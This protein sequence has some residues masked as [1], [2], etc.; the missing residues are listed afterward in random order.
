MACTVIVGGFFGDEG[1]GKIASYLAISDELAAMVRAG[2]GTNAGHTVVYKGKKFKLRQ[3]PCGFVNEK[4]K[5]Y[6]SAGMLVDPEVILKEI[7]ET[8]TKERL[9]IDFQTGIIEPIHRERDKGTIISKKIG[10]TGSGS[11]PC[12][13]DR[14]S[15]VGKIAQ[16][17][18][19]LKEY[20]CDVALEVNEFIDAQENV[21]LEGTQGTF[22]S[23]YHGTYP[24]V[25][26]KDVCASAICSDVGI[27]PT[28]IDDVLVIFK[29]YVTRVGE[30]PLEGELSEEE[31]IR[32]GWQEKGT[33]TGRTRRASPFNYKLAKRTVFLNGATQCA[34]T[35]LD[36]VFPNVRGI[37]TF[38]ELPKE[39]I[40]FTHKI[41]AQL[42]I[43]VTLIGTGPGVEEIIDRRA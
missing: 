11:G 1:K 37:K 31:T 25:T 29:A 24:Y 40:E 6:M 20:L 2:C 8:N 4:T 21:V 28:K 5:L 33:V 9:K 15:R 36:I 16:D 14:V 3:I 12:N 39:A 26:S 22:L 10:T 17:I 30:G 7:E 27:G 19:E 32:R 42:K 18:P 34:L 23:L 35:K 41:E 13:V 43:P 38:E